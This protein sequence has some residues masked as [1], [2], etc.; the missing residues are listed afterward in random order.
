[1]AAIIRIILCT[2]LSDKNLLFNQ[3]E[4]EQVLKWQDQTTKN[5]AKSLKEVT[6]T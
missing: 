6:A 1:M 5:S 3:F 4:S 2:K